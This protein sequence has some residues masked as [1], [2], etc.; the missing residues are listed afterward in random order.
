[1]AKQNLIEYKISKKGAQPMIT[2]IIKENIKFEL[3]EPTIQEIL[4]KNELLGKKVELFD[5]RLINQN[6]I[7]IIYKV[8]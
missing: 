7:E 5:N 1:M 4:I 3:W 8:N 2:K 6:I